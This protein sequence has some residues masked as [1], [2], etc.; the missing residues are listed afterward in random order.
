[1]T[2]ELNV[3]QT[4]GLAMLLFVLGRF[5][6]NHVGFLRRCCI[7][8][9]V[10]GGLIFAIFHLVVHQTGLLTLTFDETLKN[11]FMIWFF[12]SVGYGASFKVLRRGAGPVLVFLLLATVM[13]TMQN[14]VGVGFAQLFGLDDPRL[15]LCMGARP[16][17]PWPTCSASPASMAP[18]PRR[19]SWCPLWEACLWTSPIPP[20]SPCS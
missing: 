2:I 15:G 16:P 13:I 12:T 8:A 3:L 6:V 7:P 5:I 10:V 14:F 1:M 18:R 19:S 17:T 4:T 9:P 20:S 11:V